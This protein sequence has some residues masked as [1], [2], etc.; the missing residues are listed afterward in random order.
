M[1]ADSAWVDSTLKRMTLREKVGQL[2]VGDFVALYSNEKSENFTRIK[3]EIEKFHIGGI[4][5]AGG[6]VF[7]IAILTNEL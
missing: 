6:G 1:T 4:V 2:F 5:L 3:H 7:D